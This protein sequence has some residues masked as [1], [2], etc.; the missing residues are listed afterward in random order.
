M[1]VTDAV[2]NKNIAQSGVMI[3]TNGKWTQL[4][5]DFRTNETSAITVNLQRM[6]CKESV[7]P[8]LGE[9]WLDDFSLKEL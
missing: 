3:S 1:L 4:S 2:I 5:I 8:I 9:L 6:N 7:C